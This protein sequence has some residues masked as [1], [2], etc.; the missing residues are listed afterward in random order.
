MTNVD[1]S[2]VVE[3]RVVCF[4]SVNPPESGRSGAWVIVELTTGSTVEVMHVQ[5][6]VSSPIPSWSER[7]GR[8]KQSREGGKGDIFNSGCH[9][10][11][12]ISALTTSLL[13]HP[14]HPAT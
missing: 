6:Y 4:W 3:R 2:G 5:W 14:Q 7:V 10:T 11:V 9:V 1:A 8:D 13:Q 12:S